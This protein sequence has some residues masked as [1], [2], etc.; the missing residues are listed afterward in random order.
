MILKE[1]SQVIVASMRT[2]V[3]SYD[4]LFHIVPPMGAE[5]EQMGCVCAVP[6]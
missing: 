6:E 4:A 1:L 5:M 3:P 2:I